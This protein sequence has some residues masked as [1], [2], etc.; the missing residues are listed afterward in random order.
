MFYRLSITCTFGQTNWRFILPSI[1]TRL[2][3][4]MQKTWNGISEIS[5]DGAGERNWPKWSKENER[6][7]F[8]NVSLKFVDIFHVSGIHSSLSIT[9]GW[10]DFRNATT[11][12]AIIVYTRDPIRNSEARNES[13]A[14]LHSWKISQWSPRRWMPARRFRD[15]H[16]SLSRD[17]GNRRFNRTIVNREEAKIREPVIVRCLSHRETRNSKRKKLKKA[18]ERERE[19]ERKREKKRRICGN[20]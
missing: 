20:P 11:S 17:S 3:T 7:S 2:N 14:I 16:R 13:P 15:Q 10:V 19:R 8:V 9:T 12:A 1:K 6:C 4:E 5:I 18:K